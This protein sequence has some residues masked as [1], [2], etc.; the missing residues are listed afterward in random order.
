[1]PECLQQATA[2][3]RYL[4]NQGGFHLQRDACDA[5]TNPLCARAQGDRAGSASRRIKVSP[6][7]ACSYVHRKDGQEEMACGRGAIDT[8]IRG[9]GMHRAYGG[10]SCGFTRPCGVRVRKRRCTARSD[11][12]S[13]TERTAYTVAER[14][15][16]AISSYFVPGAVHA[17]GAGL[18]S[19]APRFQFP[20]EWSA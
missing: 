12:A 10:L 7:S 19:F 9:C 2:I 6:D 13:A 14:Y 3:L 16:I 11:A 4:D 18:L 5:H 20:R 8:R 1:M 15:R 17:R